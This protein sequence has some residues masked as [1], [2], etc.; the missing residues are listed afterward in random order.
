MTNAEADTDA[1]GAEQATFHSGARGEAPTR[2]H[3]R[4]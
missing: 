1:N 3:Q 2:C 4:T